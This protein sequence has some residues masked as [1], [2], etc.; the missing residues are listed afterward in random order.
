MLS[1]SSGILTH[2]A[3]GSYLVFMGSSVDSSRCID[4]KDVTFPCENCIGIQDV[5]MMTEKIQ[6][7]LK[8]M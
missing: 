1:V 4:V 2:L 8:V 6:Y 5:L 3:C 7:L